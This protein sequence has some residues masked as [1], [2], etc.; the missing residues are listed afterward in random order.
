MEAKFQRPKGREDAISALNAAVEASNLA[1]NSISDITP[2][3]NVSGSVSVLLTMI[4]VCFP[5][6]SNELL[7]V[8][9]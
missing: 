3:K 5:L 9:T 4:R 7:Q 8:H 2:A 1:E 6:L